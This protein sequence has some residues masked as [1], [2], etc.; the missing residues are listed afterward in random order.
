MDVQVLIERVEGNGYLARSALGLSAQGAT[1]EEAVRNLKDET[2]RRLANGARLTVMSL[3]PKHPWAIQ[4]SQDP[5]PWRAVT[6]IYDPNNPMIQ[7]WLAAIEEYRR[8]RD[9]DPDGLL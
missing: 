6:G 5:N 8:S 2:E 4:V 1:P 3:P 9:T 7:E